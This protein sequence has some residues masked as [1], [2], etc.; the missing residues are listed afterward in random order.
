MPFLDFLTPLPPFHEF[1]LHGQ[2][3]A[4]MRMVLGPVLFLESFNKMEN[5]VFIGVQSGYSFRPLSTSHHPR[6]KSPNCGHHP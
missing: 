4:C 1:Y 5:Q 6:L 3:A 2:Q